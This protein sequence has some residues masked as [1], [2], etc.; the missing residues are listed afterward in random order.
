[1]KKGIRNGHFGAHFS[2]VRFLNGLL[3]IWTSGKDV[4]I[5]GTRFR[6]AEA[7]WALSKAL[8]QILNKGIS[9]NGH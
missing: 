5:D 9:F 4:E 3:I 2:R 7:V 6:D 1:M 8:N